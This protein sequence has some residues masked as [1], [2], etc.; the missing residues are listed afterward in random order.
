MGNNYDIDD[1][2]HL[3]TKDAM[4]K[5]IQIYL[6][7]DDDEGIYQS[8]KE[9]I[10]NSTDE[11]LAGYGNKIRISL[12]EKTNEIK[13]RDWGRGV[14]FG[15]KN[16]R[17]VLVSIY[18]E[19]H[20]GGKFGKGVY[21]NSSGLNGLGGTAA[22]MSSEQFNVYS[23]RNGICANASFFKGD[24]QNYSECKVSEMTRFKGEESKDGTL[25]CFTPDKEVFQNMSNGFSFERICNEIKNIAYLNSGIHFIVETTGGKNK[26]FFSENGIAD[27]IKDNVKKPLMKAPILASAKDDVDRLEIAFMWTGDASQS[28]VFVNGVCCPDGGAPVT[29]AKTAITTSI[30]RFANKDFDPELIRKGLVYVINCTVSEPSFSNQTK[31]KINNPNLR[32]LASKAFKEGLEEFSNTAEFSAIMEMLSKFQKAENAADKAREAVMNHTKKMSDLRNKKVAFIKKLSDAE[33]L[34]E[35]ATLCIVEGE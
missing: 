26:E 14:P 7:S 12:N 11:V 10:N 30:K 28:Y 5:R 13:V 32:T 29:G 3:D 16:G 23:I 21:K 35:N 17:N 33:S 22:C 24:L 1:I 8:L 27:F 6:G 25:V 20:T 19:S 31:N 2:E 4:R 18:S 34:G 15:I 9:I